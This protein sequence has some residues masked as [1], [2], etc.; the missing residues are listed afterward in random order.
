MS[1]SVRSL[2]GHTAEQGHRQEHTSK[3]SVGGGSSVESSRCEKKNE[4]RLV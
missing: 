1:V 4:G 2:T 3:S